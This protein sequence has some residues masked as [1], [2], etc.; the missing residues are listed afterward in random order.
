LRRH[1][2]LASMERLL[3]TAAYLLSVARRQVRAR[4]R[5]GLFIFLLLLLL[6][7]Q[8][9]TVNILRKSDSQL[10]QTFLQVDRYQNKKYQDCRIITEAILDMLGWLAIFFSTG[11]VS[12]FNG[13]KCKLQIRMKLVKKSIK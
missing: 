4:A 5:R 6:P 7:C 2:M 11:K 1:A 13:C 3:I 10:L 8:V 9:P 12:D